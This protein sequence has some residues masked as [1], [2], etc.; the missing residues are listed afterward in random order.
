[1][2]ASLTSLP[3]KSRCLK[4][5]QTVISEIGSIGELRP[6]EVGDTVNLVVPT[7]F[8]IEYSLFDKY[9]KLLGFVR[10]LKMPHIAFRDYE[11]NNNPNQILSDIQI[12]SIQLLQEIGETI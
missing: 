1:M 10:L 2:R 12:K 3:D 9:Q 6:I 4:T 7:K 8:D 11:I 5:R